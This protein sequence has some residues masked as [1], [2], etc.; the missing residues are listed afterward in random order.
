MAMDEI[1]I[2]VSASG[3]TE[4][5]H[6]D[7]F[8]LSFLGPMNVTRASE[9]FHNPETQLWDVILPD[10]TQACAQARGF[11]GYDVARKF[12]VQWLQACRKENVHPTSPRGRSIAT[13]VRT[14]GEGNCSEHCEGCRHADELQRGR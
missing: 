2:D 6:F 5:M 7:E 1:V 14:C 13:H 8:P 9:I 3:K 10:E 12:E 4:A 11:S